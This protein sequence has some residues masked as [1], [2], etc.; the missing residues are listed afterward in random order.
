MNNGGHYNFV[1]KQ[2]GHLSDNQ[3]VSPKVPPL[4]SQ[5]KEKFAAE[6]SYLK[7]FQK[8]MIT[9]SIH[10]ADKKR[11]AL[12]VGLH[13][14][15]RAHSHNPLAER[16]T[17]ALELLQ[18]FKEYA[19]R[20]GLQIDT[21]TG[22]MEN[23]INDLQTKFASQVKLL[24]LGDYVKAL[25]SANEELKSL[26]ASRLQQQ[27]GRV[28]GALAAARRQTDNAYK[29]VI[30]MLNSLMVVEGEERYRSL[31]ILLNAE[32]THAKRELLGQHASGNTEP[33][34]DAGNGGDDGDDDVPQ[35]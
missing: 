11:D 27:A 28:V 23:L 14:M 24:A 3:S 34:G 5:L 25:S 15:I 9:D 4:L 35:G 30:Q 1:E 10:A 17:A 21:E 31:A 32:I 16:V 20:T 19:I 13:E 22:M 7:T 26:T 29:A 33:G 18:V 12:Y 2:I 8:S 6:G